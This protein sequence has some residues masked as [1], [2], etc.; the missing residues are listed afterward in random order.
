M[1]MLPDASNGWQ[2][3][4]VGHLGIVD[5]FGGGGRGNGDAACDELLLDPANVSSIRNKRVLTG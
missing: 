2:G 5:L 4:H 3:Q 1:M